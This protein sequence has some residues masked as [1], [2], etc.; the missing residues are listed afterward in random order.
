MTDA[1]SQHT[2]NPTT[3]AP[4]VPPAAPSPGLPVTPAQVAAAVPPSVWK[5]RWLL[6]RCLL[7]FC[8]ASIMG[9]AALDFIGQRDSRIKEAIVDWSYIAALAV[10]ALYCGFATWEDIARG[11]K[12]AGLLAQVG[13]RAGETKDGA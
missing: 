10:F 3:Q 2:A 12:I 13:I 6:V 1:P 9:M 4:A 7:V 8:G 11:G 5:R